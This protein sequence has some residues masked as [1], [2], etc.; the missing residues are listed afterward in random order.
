MSISGSYT[1][2]GSSGKDA[3]WDISGPRKI[4]LLRSGGSQVAEALNEGHVWVSVPMTSANWSI[5]CDAIVTLY[6]TDD[7]TA[8]VQQT[9]YFSH[10]PTTQ[11]FV[12]PVS[13]DFDI[14]NIAYFTIENA[15]RHNKNL[16]ITPAPCVVD[17]RY[18][19]PTK[20]TPPTRVYCNPASLAGG[21][22]ALW[23]Q[24]MQDGDFNPITGYVVYRATEANGSYE[25]IS[26][27]KPI[28]GGGMSVQSREG[29]GTSYYYRVQCIGTRKGFDSD[30]SSAT[31]V[32]TTEWSAP[33][34]P[35]G[36]SLSSELIGPGETASLSWIAG[37]AGVNNPTRYYEIY[38]QED[39]DEYE[40]IGTTTSTRY[41]VEP[42]PSNA[43]AY[44]FKVKAIATVKGYDSPLSSPSPDLRATFTAPSTPQGL[45]INGKLS[46][47]LDPGLKAT[48]SWKASSNGVDNPLVGYRVFQN[49]TPIGD[50]TA[51]T[52]Q[53]AASPVAGETLRLTVRAVGKW[54]MSQPSNTVELTTTLPPVP[55]RSND[56]I[57][58][59]LFFDRNDVLRFVRD[60]AISMHVVEEEYRLNGA[61]PLDMEKELTPGMRIGWLEGDEMLLYEI[62]Q[63][64]TDI[65]AMAQTFEAEHIAIAELS[66]KIVEYQYFEGETAELMAGEMLKDTDW[67]IGRVS[68]AND[69]KNLLLKFEPTWD[70]LIKMRDKFGIE[71]IPRLRYTYDGIQRYIDLLDRRGEYR[72]VRLVLDMNIQQAGIIYDDREL[73]TAL[74]GLSNTEQPEGQPS[75][76]TIE[77]RL[78][79]EGVAWSVEDGRPVD[80]PI[81]QK[82][83]EDPVATAIYGRK[84]KARYGVVEFEDIVNPRTLLQ[85]TW[86]AL[87]AYSKPKVTINLTAF[88]LSRIGYASQGIALG[89]DVVVILDPIGV[90]MM[91]RVVQFDRDVLYPEQSKP[92]IG[93]YR[94]DVVAKIAGTTDV[95]VSGG[96]GGGLELDKT[97]TQEDMAADAKAVGDALG[98]CLKKTQSTADAGKTFVVGSNGIVTLQ[99]LETGGGTIPVYD[100]GFVPSAKKHPFE[101]LFRRGYEPLMY[102]L[103][104][105]VEDVYG[106]YQWMSIGTYVP[107]ST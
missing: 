96:G 54:S 98:G 43:V 19:L 25:K 100:D 105:S 73:Y 88:D 81:G 66:D 18:V 33:G 58:Q 79:F 99:K 46:I 17:A 6:D 37:K 42:P 48:L 57:T 52:Y 4:E 68:I 28:A 56:A 107:A 20:C 89:D 94:E 72:G 34:A 76:T 36:L 90:E 77:T 24:G 16:Y 27:D 5:I 87:Q 35:L 39:V 102:T 61:F 44:R 71:V 63:P 92:V 53:V 67:K 55:P 40:L 1:F 21:T 7:R 30:I 9:L 104:V 51:T 101:L 70:S 29:N 84:G 8:S 11:T 103:L 74:Y 13:A 69:T 62:R 2:T 49:G 83:I 106:G 59:F 31:G 78:T 10:N 32:L 3:N 47:Y 15:E 26:G 45:N 86:D 95:V 23:W 85:N 60:D 91:A 22:S 38:R 50:T 64:E 80:K 82:Y 97:L 75:D 93:D 41:T 14:F 65:N 12:V